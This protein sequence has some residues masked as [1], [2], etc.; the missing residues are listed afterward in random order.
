[1][2]VPITTHHISSAVVLKTCTRVIS[3]KSVSRLSLYV[4][5]L[6]V[7]QLMI[8]TYFNLYAY[9]LINTQLAQ[10][11]TNSVLCNIRLRLCI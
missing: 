2:C 10:N 5:S 6:Q 3:T 11:Q 9:F 1:M 8:V 7:E 4:S